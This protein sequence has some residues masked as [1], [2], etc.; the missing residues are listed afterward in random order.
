MIRV[1][2]VRFLT[3]VAVIVPLIFTHAQAQTTNPIKIGVIYPISG[4]GAIYGIPTMLGNDMAIDEI[5]AK[6][7]ILGRKVVAIVR[8]DKFD[9]AVGAAAAKEL[10]TNEHVDILI[11]GMSSAVGLAISE[12]ARQ[13]KIV[14]IAT[15]PQTIQLTTT[16]LHKYVFRT[17]TNTEME[18]DAMAQVVKN[19]GIKKLC[20]LQLD[21]AYGHDLSDGVKKGLKR[22][23]PDVKMALELWPSLRP[24]IGAF[25]LIKSWLPVATV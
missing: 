15:I 4:A 13:E 11:G 22:Y 2:T 16:K 10:I 6:G 21:Y 18:G 20:N 5:N 14:Y 23:A 9:P 19:I 12:V 24:L 3:G 25:L 7:G 1:L 17:D 8:D